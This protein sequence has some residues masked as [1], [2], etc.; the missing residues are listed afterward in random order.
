MKILN[1]PVSDYDI[2]N[3]KYA[4]K[5]KPVYIKKND[6]EQTKID[7][8]KSLINADLGL[9]NQAYYEFNKYTY[10]PLIYAN[11]SEGN[12]SFTFGITSHSKVN[13][14]D[15]IVTQDV[16]VTIDQNNVYTETLEAYGCE[17]IDLSQKN[18]I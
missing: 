3:K 17:A 8:L 6:S 14:K 4:D 9:T 13:D 12:Y 7:K 10:V 1:K 18:L 2:V 5:L 15:Y 16:I 11:L